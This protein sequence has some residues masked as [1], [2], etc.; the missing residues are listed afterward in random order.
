MIET[1]LLIGAV[2]FLVYAILPWVTHV[3]L[4]DLQGEVRRLRD[5]VRAMKGQ[6]PIK[7]PAP[8]PAEN[9]AAQPAP[10][11][12]PPQKKAVAQY[13]YIARTN[14]PAE[15]LRS[16]AADG[17]PAWK[18]GFE[19][20]FGTRLPVW[21]GGIALAFAG[22]Y[23]V[24][25]SID[26]G[27]LNPAVREGLGLLAGLA[28][29]SAARKIM[30]SKKI[31]DNVRI[32][33]SL[34][35]AGVAD[36][37]FCLF[38]AT[39]LYGLISP[40]TGF[41]G[42]AVVTALAVL[43][44]LWYGAPVALLGMAGGFLTPAVMGSSHP[45]APM[46]FAYL[47]AVSLGFMIVIRQ[48]RWWTMGLLVVAAGFL[49]LAF[50]LGSGA[51]IAAAA[52]WPG[53]FL[54]ALAA[55]A[56]L[57]LRPQGDETEKSPAP[58]Y[59][60]WLTAGGSVVLMCLLGYKTGFDGLSL[61]MLWLLSAGGIVMA[62]FNNKL[63]GFV[64]PL[65][66]TAG[67]AV[68][69]GLAA[70]PGRAGLALIAFS[71][72]YA[73]SGYFLQSR[74]ATPRL[75]SGLATGSVLLFYLIGYGK[76][77]NTLHLAAG[78]YFWGM[79]ALTLGAVAACI[80]GKLH[81]DIPDSN[82][83]K[84]FI[85]GL[86][87]AAATAFISIC[88]ALELE[89]T[90]LPLAIAG[91]VLALCWINARSGLAVFRK[92]AA[93]LGCVYGVLMM[94][95][96]A[97]AFNVIAF[98]SGYGAGM[99]VLWHPLVQLA[100]PAALFLAAATF[101]RQREDGSLPH[102]LEISAVLLFGAGAHFFAY[103]ILYPGQNPLHITSNFTERGILTDMMFAY[104][105]FCLYAGRELGRKSFVQAGCVLMALA[106]V[107]V[108]LLDAVA[109]NPLFNASQNVGGVPLLNSL[110]LTYGVP[111][112]LLATTVW[113]LPQESQTGNW[114]KMLRFAMLALGFMLVSLE[115]R[116]AFHGA[117]LAGGF[118]S[119]AE[120]YAYSLAWM[121]MAI[122]LLFYGTL[123]HNKTMRIVALALMILVVCK[124]FLYDAAALQGLLR[125]A[126]FFGL[127]LSLLALSWFYT[128]FIVE[129]V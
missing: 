108:G 19:M 35:G 125:V 4:K 51:F 95:K 70:A 36:L 5:E 49:W 100:L 58:K 123:K 13:T 83:H 101:L 27:W 61:G 60:S 25:Y 23:F 77:H 80:T 26:A 2:I 67:A 102:R 119:N 30:N 98:G 114:G 115:V 105:A 116:Q 53:L 118:T 31:A 75:W 50:W 129:K 33:Q 24:R 124:V 104:A 90:F 32:A 99:S 109:Y 126:S 9:P 93:V 66:L 17:A 82:V 110:L 34:A 21:I 122:G 127:G 16:S 78:P 48:R 69:A 29:I 92:L 59:F 15:A 38:A 52:F 20:Q 11:P 37:Y 76:L 3:Q 106:V 64:P 41:A 44:S 81:K 28:G 6:S 40:V 103:R 121:V 73:A 120:I 62:R 68:L 1:L 22:F 18:R 8:V 43:L 86:Y 56:V 10:Q 47:Y 91:E 74:T 72:L 42:M 96:V 84:L 54:L 85:V 89:H 65:A 97:L 128:R 45:S 55:T 12:A 39:N 107:R 113:L 87:A 111:I 57:L 71:A 63:Y 94:F 112:P 7:A 79:L 46:F 88:L 14:T 117:H